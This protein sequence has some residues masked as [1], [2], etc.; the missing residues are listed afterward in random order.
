MKVGD[1][2]TIHHI[3]PLGKIDYFG[4]IISETIGHGCRQFKPRLFQ[5]YDNLG[6]IYDIYEDDLSLIGED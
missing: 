5:V 1:L 6:D 4:V 3:T 2:V